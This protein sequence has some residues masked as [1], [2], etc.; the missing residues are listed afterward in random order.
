M[1]GLKEEV[2]SK[3]LERG[4]VYEVGGCVRD[5]LLD[6]DVPAKD[7]DY[8]V[9]GI[10]LDD[11]IGLLRG[12]GRVDLV[13]KSFGVI[14]FTAHNNGSKPQPAVDIAIPRK[15]Y[16]TGAAHRAFQVDFDHTLPIES[17]LR[18]RDFTINAMAKDLA[19]GELVDPLGGQAD[20]DNRIL[21]M[22][23][24]ANFEE[25][26][27]RILRGVQ[28]AA[29]FELSIEKETVDAMRQDV[30]LVSTVTAERI[31]E[32]LTKLLTKSS[33][34]SIGFRLMRQIGLL[35]LILPE[36]AETVDV[37]QPG[38]Y[39]AYDV[40]EHLL[41]TTD[42]AAPSL[43]LRWAAL[44]HDI[45]K[46]QA[47]RTQQDKATFYGHETS[48]AKNAMR[49]LRRLR[50]PNELIREVGVLVERHMFTIPRTDKGL[51]RLVRKTGVNL[52][53]D[54]LDLRRA[55]VIGQGMG[56]KTDD[57]DEF[58]TRIR[59]ELQRKP[60]FSVTDLVINGEDV[61]RL[62]RIPESPQVGRILSYL[63]DIVLEDPDKNTR[64]TLIEAARDYLDAEETR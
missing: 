22:I 5:S 16:S 53:F 33:K 57:V 44:L 23:D 37:S 4:K 18:R 42:A 63:L 38:G 6:R 36:L 47:K 27:L 15:E 14:K 21:R 62:L 30:G 46:P 12:F 41:C 50:Y 8:V 29:R 25:D 39:H 40:F 59:E 34:P 7:R 28:F 45:T 51:R 20:L 64:E 10:P 19:T 9:T 49:M 13:G 24:P 48:S 58:E 1:V 61:M 17:D 52:I 31:G 60:P 56:N 32:E 43:R 2:L 3:L 26:P 54:L 11:L 35:D 55:D